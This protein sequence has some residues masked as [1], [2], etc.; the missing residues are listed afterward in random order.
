M[1]VTANRFRFREA[2]YVKV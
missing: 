2:N 1:A